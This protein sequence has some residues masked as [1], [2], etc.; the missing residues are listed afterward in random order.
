[1]FC[2]VKVDPVDQKLFSTRKKDKSE[3]N[4]NFKFAMKL[5]TISH[6]HV[7]DTGKILRDDNFQ[8]CIIDLKL[9]INLLSL[10]CNNFV[11]MMSST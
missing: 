6:S 9:R 7:K 3:N 1:M 10:E 11:Q 8:I 5:L 2:Y 4:I